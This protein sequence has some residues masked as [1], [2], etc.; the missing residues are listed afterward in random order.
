[1]KLYIISSNLFGLVAIIG[2]TKSND[3]DSVNS[4]K[5]ESKDEKKTRVSENS[6]GPWSADGQSV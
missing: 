4:H 2:W 3:Q 1:M 5:L 6:K